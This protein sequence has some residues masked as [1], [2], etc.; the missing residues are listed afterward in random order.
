MVKIWIDL[1]FSLLFFSS[2]SLFEHSFILPFQRFSLFFCSPSSTP[3][4][5]LS[6]THVPYRS[7]SLRRPDLIAK[8]QSIP[9]RP[10]SHYYLSLPITTKTNESISKQTTTRYCHPTD[11][12][13]TLIPTDTLPLFWSAVDFLYPNPSRPKYAYLIISNPAFSSTHLLTIIRRH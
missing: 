6:S 11:N 10:T 13:S 7:V 8:V 1:F 3:S 2:S 5:V 4:S 12:S 9:Y